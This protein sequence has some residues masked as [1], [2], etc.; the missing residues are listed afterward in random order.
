MDGNPRDGGREG[1]GGLGWSPEGGLVFGG[2]VIGRLPIARSVEQARSNFRSLGPMR[3]LAGNGGSYSSYSTLHGDCR[4]GTLRE[5]LA[6][7][8]I[9]CPRR[10]NC[11]LRVP[12][13]EAAI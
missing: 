10:E 9:I 13:P 7:S 2:I 3:A 11:F 12:T 1:G 5:V 8:R 6:E 4:C